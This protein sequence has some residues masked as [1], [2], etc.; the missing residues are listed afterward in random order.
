MSYSKFKAVRTEVDGIKFASKAE[1]RR[2]VELK[3][4]QEAGKISNLELQPKFPI[5]VHGI[6]VCSY[7]ADFRYHDH[8][9][10]KDGALLGSI[11][12]EDVKGMLTPIYR[13]KKK[14]MLACYN[15]TIT[16]VK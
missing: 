9:I 6:K 4:L 15:I 3:D 8:E 13:L 14:L 16:E 7:I 2:Y 12:I 5:L 11:V 10:K 1:A